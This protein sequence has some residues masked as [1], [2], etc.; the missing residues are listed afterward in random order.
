MIGIVVIEHCVTVYVFDKTVGPLIYD[1]NRCN[2]TLYYSVYL[3]IVST[4][5]HM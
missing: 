3:F 1:S 2:R 4:L 5:K